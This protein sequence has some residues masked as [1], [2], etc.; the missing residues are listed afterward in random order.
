MIIA[1]V[2]A[3][4]VIVMAAIATQTPV[5]EAGELSST[6]SLPPT[7]GRPAHPP[8]EDEGFISSVSFG[9]W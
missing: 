6:F 3:A 1:L 8:P 4:K 2:K 7:D 5:R 9:G